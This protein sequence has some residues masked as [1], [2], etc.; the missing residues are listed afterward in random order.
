MTPAPRRLA[1]LSHDERG[2][3]LVMTLLVLFGLGS[4]LAAYLAIGGIEPQISRNLAD[5]ARA[6]YLAEAGIERG[7]NVLVETA[8][9]DGTWSGLLAGAT[10]EHPWVAIA[11]LTNTPVG[12]PTNGTFSVTLRND[13]GAADTRLTGLTAM[14]QPAMDASASVDG[15]RAVIMR[16]AGVFNRATTTIEVV[17]QRAA[18]PAGTSTSP[19]SLRALRALHSITNWREI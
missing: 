5:G 18:L 16:S 8:D 13:R 14:T 4:L 6:R 9:A 3:A 12:A 15:N 7:L 11:G 19:E 17:V 2:V 1:R 10:L